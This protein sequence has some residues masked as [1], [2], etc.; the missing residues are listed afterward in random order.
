MTLSSA[1]SELR[2][3]AGARHMC[4]ARFNPRLR[5]LETTA[6]TRY[7]FSGFELL[8]VCCNCVTFAASFAASWPGLP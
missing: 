5:A 6:F 2:V 4:A 8:Y 1:P 7:C 3:W